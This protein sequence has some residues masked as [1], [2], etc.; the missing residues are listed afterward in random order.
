M[1]KLI[2]L[3][4]MLVRVLALYAQ[5]PSDGNYSGWDWTDPNPAHWQVRNSEGTLDYDIPPPFTNTNNSHLMAEIE[6]KGDYTQAKGWE[7]LWANLTRPS[8]PCFILYN[9]HRS[10]VRAFFYKNDATAYNHTM[11]TLSFVYSDNPAVLSF[12]NEYQSS[13][14]AYRDTASVG[15]NDMISVVIPLAHGCWGAADFPVML[16]NYI[17]DT[18]Y[19]GKRWRFNLYGCNSE[20]IDLSGAAGTNQEEVKKILSGQY[21]MTSPKTA[22]QPNN[23][24]AAEYAKIHKPIKDIKGFLDEMKSSAEAIKKQDK[25]PQFLADYSDA[26]LGLGDVFSFASAVVSV[27]S[28][29]SA[30]LGFINAITGIFGSSNS[31]PPAATTQYIQLSG[32]ITGMYLL[33]PVELTIPG[34][35]GNYFPSNT[36][37]PTKPF[38]CPMGLVNLQNT[39]T[40]QSSSYYRYGMDDTNL[41]T[42][43]PDSDGKFIIHKN[44]NLPGYELWYATKDYVLE[45][46]TGKFKKYKFDGNVILTTQT[47]AGLEPLKEEDVLLAIVCKPNGKSNGTPSNTKYNVQDQYIAKL[48]FF[49]PQG[50]SKNFNLENPVYNA[51]IEGKF[52]IHKFDEESGEVYFG[53][54]WMEVDKLKDVVLEVPEDT[55]VKLAVFAKFYSTYYDEP[56]IFKAMYNLKE[57]PNTLTR[58]SGTNE[59]NFL[60]S[61]Y[62]NPYSKLTLNTTK[63]NLNTATVIEMTEGFVGN[64][65]FIAE[66]IPVTKGLVNGNTV[67]NEVNFPCGSSPFPAKRVD[68]EFETEEIAEQ[69]PVFYP[70]PTRGIVYIETKSEDLLQTI[71][72]FAANGQQLQ[73]YENLNA[74]NGEIDLS[75][76]ND[77]MYI[78]T[79]KAGNKNYSNKIILQK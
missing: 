13:T 57:I 9:R 25:P 72:V 11:V 42:T 37:N 68:G 19:Q 45:G 50:V 55:D 71:S 61:D 47:I 39:P 4:M 58:I 29:V 17:E 32:T 16:D 21:T 14:I 38:N 56:I 48:Q 70:N 20:K 27:S 35:G 40:I 75:E 69:S 28:G 49:N 64:E 33:P 5:V 3:I 51:L 79:L 12:G 60:F 65:G 63:N 1:K 77:G 6:E 10:I 31:T 34:T 24:F 59:Y 74:T 23:N 66:T 7:L 76:L 36:W 15:N 41:Y 43:V 44:Y 54:P 22:V 53:T 8:Y 73:H 2:L 30:V 62:Y 78:I 67:I 46:Y 52:I 18:D 26:I